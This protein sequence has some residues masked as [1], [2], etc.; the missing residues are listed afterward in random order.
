V[1][2]TPN[3]AIEH[4]LTSQAQKEVTANEAFDAIDEA[5][6]DFT[7][8]DVSAG[9]TTVS[10]EDFTRN[11]L[12]VLTGTPAGA[13][14]LTVPVSKR[15]FIAQNDCGQDVAVTAGAGALI[16]TAGQRRLLYGDG[17]NI[18][19]VAPDFASTGG[20]SGGGGGGFPVFKG[21]L[22]KRTTNV[23]IASNVLTTLDWEGE[24]YDTDGFANVGA[25]PTRLTVPSGKGIT[26]VQVLCGVQ[27]A[28]SSSG[29]RWVQMVKNGAEVD[30]MPGYLGPVDTSSRSRIALTS[31]PIVVTDGDYFEC[32]VWQNASGSLDVEADPKTW[33][34]IV[35]IEFAAFR[36]AM[37]KLTAA[38]AVTSSVDTA[39]PWDATVYDTDAF[40]SAGSPT[41]LTVPTG[42]TRVR[43]K[44]N[45]DWTFGGG[46]YR[47]IWTH[48]NGA[49]FFGGAKESDEGDAGIQSIGSAVVQVTPGDYF[50][51]IVR[52]TSGSTKNVAADELT[53]FAIEV[54]E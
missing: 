21:A 22:I 23:T 11:V 9:N 51:L 3:L 43:L 48:M 44:G 30:G 4:I 17:T 5:M 49:L 10:V 36:G 42:V 38:E 18:V 20:G 13:L 24:V 27:W 32:Q 40:W 52:Q 12:L 33:F 35:A 47:H 2:A 7:A 46:G 53:W 26:R 16:L 45:I 50:E 37:V 34:A 39:I 54:V 29:D 14:D 28:A 15:L 1:S 41:R 6:N 8:I 31:A 25:Q 19:A